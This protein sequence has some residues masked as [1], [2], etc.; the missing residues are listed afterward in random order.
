M[1][2][3][4]FILQSIGTGVRKARLRAS[5]GPR[6]CEGQPQGVV[7]AFG[8]G[9]RVRNESGR[10]FGTG[11]GKCRPSWGRLSPSRIRRPTHGARGP[12]RSAP[13]VRRSTD[14][15]R[16]HGATIRYVYVQFNYPGW[17]LGENCRKWRLT[18]WKASFGDGFRRRPGAPARG[19]RSPVGTLLA[20]GPRPPRSPQTRSPEYEPG[21]EP[22]LTR[23]TKT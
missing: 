2:K 21:I 15:V 9:G 10:R 13:F 11:G 3:Q 1:S 17:G 6:G 5:C 19:R 16:G 4:A 8:G 14:P 12:K 20:E 7:R 23:P 18:H 22:C